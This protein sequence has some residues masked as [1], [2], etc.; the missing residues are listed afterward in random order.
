MIE[1]TLA[2]RERRSCD[3]DALPPEQRYNIVLPGDVHGR[4]L[5]RTRRN[6]RLAD[7]NPYADDNV[8]PYEEPTAERAANHDREASP[9]PR[10]SYRERSRSPSHRLPAHYRTRSPS[11]RRRFD[12]SR[13]R[14][15]PR[16]YRP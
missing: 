15:R 12:T 8:K 13:S 10:E 1:A 16:E 2:R 6:Q 7:R 11:P 3:R 9:L 4:N 14:P 5:A